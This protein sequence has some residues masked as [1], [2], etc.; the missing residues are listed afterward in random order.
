M[1]SNHQLLEKYLRKLDRCLENISVSEKAEIITE[2]RCHVLETQE[3]EPEKSI[4]EILSALGEPET[5]ANKYLME[6]GQSPHKL[7]LIHI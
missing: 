1:N 3:R 7:S 4:Q 5:V 2:I 6:K